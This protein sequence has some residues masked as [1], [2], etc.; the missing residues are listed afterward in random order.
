MDQGLQPEG[1][2]PHL[3]HFDDLSL[4]TGQD[5]ETRNETGK[6]LGLCFLFGPLKGLEASGVGD[7]AGQ[8]SHLPTDQSSEL[9]G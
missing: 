1:S 5:D 7:G 4:G 8:G 3:M 9:L 2:S 6:G